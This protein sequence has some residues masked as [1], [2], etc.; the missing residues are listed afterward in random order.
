ME[1][2]HDHRLRLSFDPANKISQTE[3][4]GPLSVQTNLKPDPYSSIALTPTAFLPSSHP[5]PHSTHQTCLLYTWASFAYPH[6]FQ[7]SRERTPPP[8][9]LTTLNQPVYRGPLEQH[10]LSISFF[11]SSLSLPC[12]LAGISIVFELLCMFHLLV[13]N[14]SLAYI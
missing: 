14:L 7:T 6:R 9:S 3:G 5:P 13:P 8:L 12:G 10:C 1:N 2:L 4:P 11:F